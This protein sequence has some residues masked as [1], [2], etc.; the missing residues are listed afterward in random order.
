MVGHTSGGAFGNPLRLDRPHAKIKETS[1]SRAPSKD[2]RVAT[3]VADVAL[4]LDTKEVFLNDVYVNVM[5]DCVLCVFQWV[6]HGVVSYAK[7]S[8]GGV[9]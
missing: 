4:R 9:A 7:V 8:V 2:T 6:K 3:E 5:L 1:T